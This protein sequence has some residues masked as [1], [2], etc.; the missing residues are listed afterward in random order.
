MSQ[1]LRMLNPTVART[2]TC[3]IFINQIRQKIGTMGYG[4]P[5]TTTG[6]L[7]LKFYSSVRMDIRRIGDVKDGEEKIG[8]RTKVK[9]VKNKVAAPF[10][11]TEFDLMYDRGIS[12]EGDVVELRGRAA[13]PG[14]RKGQGLPAR[15]PR[16][17][18][19]DRAQ[20]DREAQ[21]E[22]RR[23]ADG[24]QRRDARGQAGKA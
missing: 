10:R 1:A 4:D 17:A 24:H 19:R 23:H 8:S 20:G 11:Q 21:P 5:N 12:R 16:P 6:G 3:L 18:E 7:A 14:S 13:G 22:R 9:V 2:Q 15:E